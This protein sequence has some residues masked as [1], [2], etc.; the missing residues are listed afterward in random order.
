MPTI[1]ELATPCLLIER[2]RLEANVTGMQARA[3]RTR[4][5]LRPH[6]K[7]HKMVALAALQRSQG[8][9]GITVAKVG[10]AEVFAQAGFGDIRIAYT[11]VGR[12]KLER[13]A[14][15][16]PGL[17]FCVDSLK[18]ARQ[19]SEVFA[20]CDKRAKV[21]LEIDAGYGRCGRRWDDPSLVAF[22]QRVVEL[23]GLEFTGILTHEGNAYKPGQAE[24]VMAEARDRMLAVASRLGEV[25]LAVPGRFDVS[26]GS[27][28]SA[29]H[30][31]N[32][33]QSGFAITEIRPGNY[34][35]NDFTQV[36]LGVCTL[37]DC[38]LTVLTTVIS[39][40]RDPDGTERFFV[41][42]GRKVLTSD[43]A[44]LSDEYGR[45]L[46]HP[47]NMVPH[48]HTRLINLSE[49]HGWGAVRGGSTLA[50]G[51]RVRVV[52]N[53]ACVVVNTQEEAYVVDGDEVVATWRVDARGCVQ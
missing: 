26:V 50:V 12:D 8:A 36:N 21:L 42:A 52:P 43:R 35:F 44:P 40:H 20:S 28:P 22:A 27:T 29:Y 14:A 38:A 6:T 23:R 18:A 31:A 37:K 49:E 32:A 15:L 4:V 33:T 48:P 41:D 24:P 13:I 1:D 25:G 34:V 2:R 46:Y 16:G 30:F 17:S 53:H 51:D 9:Q 3:D 11:V 5:A 7:T 47:R 19:A 39:R 45:L 10:E